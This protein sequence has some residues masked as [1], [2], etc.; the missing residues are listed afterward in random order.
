MP[1]PR[2]VNNNPLP[3]LRPVD[4]GVQ[5]VSPGSGVSARAGAPFNPQTI[6]IGLRV[7]SGEIRYRLGDSGVNALVG[8]H[9]LRTTDGQRFVSIDNRAGLDTHIAAWGFGGA[10]VVEVEEFW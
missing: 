2:D 10:A 4:G 7:I 9:R 5:T 6:V 1:A 3:Y 8:D